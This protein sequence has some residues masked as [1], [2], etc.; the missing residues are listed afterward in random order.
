LGRAALAVRPFL[1]DC[2]RVGTD[3]CVEILERADRSGLLPRLGGMARPNGVV[4]ASDRFWAF[5]TTN[6]EVREGTVACAP[7]WVSRIP[8]LRGLVHLARAV[9]PIAMRGGA[10]GG[11]ERI[12]LLAAL[13]GP[14][15]LLPLLPPAV[16]L[17]VGL[18][19][20][21]LLV[22]W[23][24]RGRTLRLHG[25]EH[26]AIAAAELGV[27]A[28]TWKGDVS[29][30]R[31]ASRCGTNFAVLTFPVAALFERLW[32]VAALPALSTAFVALLALG[33]TMELWKAIQHPSGL[34]RG[35]L[36]PGLA[37]Q[38]LTTRE[39]TLADTRLALCATASVLRRELAQPASG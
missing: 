2:V 35:L 11:R 20:G 18:A 26:R 19:L 24:M 28:S 32:P 10:A 4:I 7:G 6:G 21:V 37:L 8:F 17:P 9:R 36:L 30:T 13:V 5:A 27:L 22:G 14:L 33:A 25:A 16:E 15:F 34:L 23:L 3:T 1:R 31:F 12:F 38:R 29:P 39:P